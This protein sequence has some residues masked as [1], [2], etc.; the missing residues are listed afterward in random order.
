MKINVLYYL[1][2]TN[3]RFLKE[4]LKTKVADDENELMS[5]DTD[6]NRTPRKLSVGIEENHIINIPYRILEDIY[7]DAGEILSTLNGVLPLP[8]SS[9]GKTYLVA[10]K[11]NPKEPFILSL[12]STPTRVVCEK[13]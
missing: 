2:F 12:F 6:E 9:D 3:F 13:K 10:N 4:P 5:L 1:L 8:G 11:D 7:R